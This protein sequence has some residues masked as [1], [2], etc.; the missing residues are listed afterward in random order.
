MANLNKVFLIGRLTRDPELRRTQSGS[1]VSE[2]RIAVNRLFTVDSERRE[3]TCYVDIRVWGRR[4]EICHDYL[5]KGSQ[6]FVEGRLV[7]DEWT[8]NE[9]QKRSKLRVV[10]E[11]FQFLD[12][13]R[14]DGKRPE[15]PDEEK[16]ASDDFLDNDLQETTSLDDRSTENTDFDDGIP[17]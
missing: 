6:I 4:A 2:F 14:K 12:D 1:S 10:A 11:N 15:I 5:K 3:E 13:N 8:T 16:E 17:F 9:G 7:L